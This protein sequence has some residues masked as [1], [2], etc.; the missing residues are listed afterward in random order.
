MKIRRN[1]SLLLIL[2]LVGCAARSAA[3]DRRML[4]D[5][6]GIWRFEIGDDMNRARQDFDDRGWATVSVPSPW[7]D[8]GFPGYDGYGWYRKHFPAKPEWNNK[9]LS[10]R[11]G[12]ID[13][14]EEVYVNGHF[15]GFSGSFPPNYISA[16]N[17]F[18]QYHLPAEFLNPSGDNIIAVRVFDGELAGG[19]TRGEV[20]IVEMT[21]VL[22]PDLALQHGWKF[23]TGD[24]AQFREPG[25]DDAS[26]EKIR[27]PAYWETEGHK[28]YDGY[29]WYRLRFNAPASLAKERVILVLG[30][31]DDY[32][33]AYFN[34]Q[35]IGRTGHP[36]DFGRYG[37][38][39]N[40]YRKL[41]A[42]T[43]PAG[44]LLPDQENVIAVRVF[45]GFLH[46]GIYE[47]PVGLVTRDR[48]LRW[49]R[50]Q[51]DGGSWIQ[52]LIDSFLR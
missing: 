51:G 2:M 41:R 40:D 27:V 36:S 38:L 42:Y 49:E 23:R 52:R 26:W 43:L 32:D 9:T 18:R 28:G 45:D 19:I 5:L 22:T 34:G 37:Y 17:V 15:I 46:G 47:G 6:R 50:R 1:A 12:V 31:I 7:E 33:E 3:E 21:D 4:L 8:E 14:V 24:E 29:G 13:D 30:K 48:Y 11:L 20:A 39:S 35:R 16:Y 10:L 25:F 44:L